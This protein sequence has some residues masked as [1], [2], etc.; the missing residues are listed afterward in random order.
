MRNVLCLSSGLFLALLSAVACSSDPRAGRPSNGAGGNVDGGSS[1]SAGTPASAGSG[2][3]SAGQ[4]TGG[5]AGAVGSAGSNQGGAGGEAPL[6]CPPPPPPSEA[7]SVEEDG[8]TFTLSPGRLK[9][10]VCQSD[11]IRVAYTTADVLPTKE[12]LSVNR[13]WDK[14]SFCVAEDTD[15]VTITTARLKAKIA[16]ANGNV[17]YTDLNDAVVLAEDAKSLTPTTVEGVSTQTVETVFASP[18]DEGLFGLGQHQ[19][20]LMNRKGTDRHI[21]QQNME[22]AIPL[23]V[24]SRGYGVLWDNTSTS[25][26]FGGYENDTK[27]RY[28]S[29]AGELVDYYFFYG[30]SVDQVI[31]GYRTATGAAPLFAKW[32]YGLFQ[33]KDKYGSQAE[34]IAVKDGYRNGGIPVDVIVQDWD[35]WNPYAWGSHFMDESR[36]PDPAGLIDDLHAANVHTMI[37]IWPQYQTVGAPLKA[38]ELDNYQALDAIGALLPSSGSHHYYDVFDAEARELVYQQIHDRLL[39][40]YGWDGIW[41]DCDEPD[42]YPDSVNVRAA[43]TAL[44]KGA[45]YANAY[46]LQHTR[47]LYEGWRSLGPD[48]K[49]VYVL[50]R[51]A[52]AGQQRYS[53]ASWSGDINCDFPTFAKQIPAGLG[54]SISGIPYWTTDIGGYWGHSLDWSQA[55]NNELF[56]RWFQFGTFS[57]IFRVHGGGSRE[58]YG[59]QWSAETKATLLTFDKLRYR[60]MPY[61]YSLAAKVTNEGYTIMRHLVFDFQNDPNV[62]DI[63]DQFMFGPALMVSPVTTAGATS[64][65]VYVPAG[66][67]YDFW[68]GSTSSG[69]SAMTASAPLSQIPLMVRAGSIVPMG[70][71]IQYATESVDPLEIRVYRGADATFTLYEDE[72]DTYDYETGA[73]AQITF[74][75]N[76]ATQELTISART[77]SFDGMLM[78]RTFNIVWVGQDH[79]AGVA[80]TAAADE[81]VTYDGSQVVVSAQ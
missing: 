14:P 49:R 24:S 56:T 41:A 50:S 62:F 5:A 60:L 33:S 36:Y 17:T 66:S 40:N 51:S 58:L 71:D 23:L 21:Q 64:R 65:S 74:S 44:G 63:G 19:D 69:G 48:G 15:T 67:W 28:V 31:A 12:S 46:P 20:G 35:Y 11:I 77:G 1:G 53:A 4:A 7:Y 59:N 38:G 61:I 10:Q 54:F 68:T 57:S 76:E 32:A 30:P 16:K 39:G 26:F 18:A 34:L 22:I 79:G 3:G 72:G 78:N 55:S 75:W 42:G 73:S 45:L 81:I 43:D 25:D 80:V 27:Y 8:L 2:G 13:A 52:Y 70:P 6:V 47:A 37:S 9:V 29:E